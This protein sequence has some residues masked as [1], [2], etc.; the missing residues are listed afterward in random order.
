MSSVTITIDGQKIE[1]RKGENLLKVA[2][3]NGFD[4]PG[5]CYHTKLSPTGACRLCMVKM[6]DSD[7]YVMSCTVQ[8][9]DGL[10]IIAFDE[11]L[12]ETRKR[13][14]EYLLAEHNEECD[15]TYYDEFR[16]LVFRYGLDDPKKRKYPKIT[17]DL[18]FKID[19]SSPVLSYD[20]SKCITCFRCIKACDEVQGKNVLSFSERG[21]NSHIIAGLD[22]WATSECDG[23]GECATTGN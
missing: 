7:A 17:G 5:L 19:D 10:E 22:H 11:E 6:Q 21:I 14:L 2:R 8:T 18:N 12:E 3:E 16:D 23:C 15:G 9:E 1:T 20:A 13:T 4:I